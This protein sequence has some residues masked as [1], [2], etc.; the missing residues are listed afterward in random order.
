VNSWHPPTPDLKPTV[1]ANRFPLSC[2]AADSWIMTCTRANV[3]A[4]KTRHVRSCVC[5]ASFRVFGLASQP[6][7]FALADTRFLL[8]SRR[9]R[10][11]RRW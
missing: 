10:Q 11:L 1:T 3:S 6:A 8:I 5:E 9:K 2:A 7:A 4:D